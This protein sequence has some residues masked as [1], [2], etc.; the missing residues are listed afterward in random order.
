MTEADHNIIHVALNLD[1]EIVK[2]SHIG[3]VWKVEGHLIDKNTGQN[4]PEDKMSI[5]SAYLIKGSI[6][7]ID[8]SINI[9]S[10]VEKGAII[11]YILAILMAIS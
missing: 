5:Y 9:I 11:F 8:L 3:Q 7:K 1:N 2:N 4:I 10:P 6:E